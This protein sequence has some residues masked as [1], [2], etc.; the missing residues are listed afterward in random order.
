MLNKCLWSDFP[1]GTSGKKMPANAGDER[2]A[3][4]IPRS[5]RY[6]GGGNGTPFQYFCLGNSMGRVPGGL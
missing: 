6:L 3:G 5:G 1:G 2:D 4:L